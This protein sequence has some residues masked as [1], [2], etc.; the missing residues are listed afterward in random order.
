[1]IKIVKGIYMFSGMQIYI[2]ETIRKE[3]FHLWIKGGAVGGESK[4]TVAVQII[5]KMSHNTFFY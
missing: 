1:V 5:E 2:Q 4:I 3:L